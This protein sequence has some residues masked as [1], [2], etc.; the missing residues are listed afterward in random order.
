M[1][2][3]CYGT[4]FKDILLSVQAIDKNGNIL[5]IPSSK[6]KFDYR[7]SNLPKELIFLSA[8]LKGQKKNQKDIESKINFL[9]EKKSE[10]AFKYVKTV[11]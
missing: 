8:S 5:T 6:I 3:G 4:E 7:K 1:N 10:T 9:K 2:S 11:E